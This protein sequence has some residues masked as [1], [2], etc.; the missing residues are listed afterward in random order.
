MIRLNTF[1]LLLISL[2]LFGGCKD[3]KNDPN[4]VFIISDE[5]KVDLWEELSLSTRQLVFNISTVDNLSC[6]NFQLAYSLARPSGG[7]ILSL[8]NVIEPDNC[9]PGDAP[10][11]SIVPIGALES[12]NY[13]IEINLKNNDIVNAGK[14]FVFNDRYQLNLNTEYGLVLPN[15]PL[16]RVP[17]QSYW[18][19]IG[20]KELI[21]N[22]EDI[23]NE[24]LQSIEP[25]VIHGNNLAGDYG[26]FKVTEEETIEIASEISYEERSNF[27]FKLNGSEE[28]LTNA[29]E[30]LRTTYGEIID[31]KIFT[32]TGETL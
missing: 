9:E 18:G 16:F 25:I 3:S 7:I 10:A 21:N 31:I 5:L 27:F 14:F 6:H 4:E 15:E 24:F 2:I 30:A 29:I 32:S 8:N 22:S 1:V 26:Y 12:G 11:R 17:N 13:D 28:E 23:K 20:F 19:Y